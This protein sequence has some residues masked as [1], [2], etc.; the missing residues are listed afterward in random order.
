MLPTLSVRGDVVYTDKSYRRGNGIKIGD[1]V[2]FKHPMVVGEQGLK[3]VMG[4]G[5][6]FVWDGK[7]RGRERMIQVCLVTVMAGMGRIA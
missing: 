7:E 1:L 3:R 4:L 5:G 2:D 6:D